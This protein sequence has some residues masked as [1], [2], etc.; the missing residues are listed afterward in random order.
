VLVHELADIYCHNNLSTAQLFAL[1]GARVTGKA[2]ITRAIFPADFCE[3][4]ITI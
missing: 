4:E 3:E 2:I 1:G